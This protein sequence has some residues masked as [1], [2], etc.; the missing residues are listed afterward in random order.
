MGNL[1]CAPRQC[2][3]VE[4]ALDQNDKDLRSMVHN[5]ADEA[6][7]NAQVRRQTYER[8][9]RREEARNGQNGHHVS[10]NC[11]ACITI[12]TDDR[13]EVVTDRRE[14]AAGLVIQTAGPVARTAGQVTQPGLGPCFN[15]QGVFLQDLLITRIPRGIPKCNQ[16]H[17]VATE[18]MDHLRLELD[19]V[20]T[21]TI[22]LSTTV[23]RSLDNTDR[24]QGQDTTGGDEPN[25]R[26]L[27]HSKDGDNHPTQGPRVALCQKIA[28]KSRRRL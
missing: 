17:M 4:F 3:R 2:S 21:G 14:Q 19:G 18:D 5:M 25:R 16:A 7:M 27:D 1:L 11:L 26:R 8:R 15:L 9:R 13:Q 6:G 20:G 22:A 28:L 12:S 10:V 23:V 24:R